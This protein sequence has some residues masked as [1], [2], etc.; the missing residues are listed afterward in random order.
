MMYVIWTSRNNVTR[1]E[2]GYNPS[3]SMEFIKEALHTLELPKTQQNSKPSRLACT[4]QGPPDGFIK[5]NSM[6]LLEWSKIWRQLELWH[7]KRPDSRVQY[8]S[9]ML[10]FQ[11][12]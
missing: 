8:A 6:G 4:W 1:G 12:L 9:H 7:V 11:I 3:K 2:A 10:G 5:V